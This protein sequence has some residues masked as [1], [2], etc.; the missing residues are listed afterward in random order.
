M[1]ALSAL[2]SGFLGSLCAFEAQRVLPAANAQP[3]FALTPVF[4]GAWACALLDERIDPALAIS[5]LVM[6]GAALL[7]STDRSVA[8]VSASAA[9][10]EEEDDDDDEGASAA[11]AA[12]RDHRPLIA[13]AQ[14]S[15]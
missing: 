9:T 12:R 7:A 6:I 8:S 11:Q 1:L 14:R 5:A 3:F 2:L 10:E 4:G 15:R 13:P